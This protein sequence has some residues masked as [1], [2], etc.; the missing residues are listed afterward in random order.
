MSGDVFILFSIYL[1]IWT[2]VEFSTEIIFLHIHRFQAFSTKKS[3]TILIPE[4]LYE[5]YFFLPW[6]FLSGIGEDS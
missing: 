4:V 2:H 1:R 5:S 3:D 6:K